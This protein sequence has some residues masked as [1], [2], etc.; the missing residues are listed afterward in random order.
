MLA[1]MI[2]L[3]NRS[4]FHL[5]S[6]TY[7]ISLFIQIYLQQFLLYILCTGTV[8]FCQ[9]MYLC[10]M[11]LYVWKKSDIL[12]FNVVSNCLLKMNIKCFDRLQHTSIHIWCTFQFVELHQRSN[13]VLMRK[14]GIKFYLYM[15]L[16]LYRTSLCIVGQT[17]PLCLLLKSILV[18]TGR[19]KSGCGGLKLLPNGA[20][21]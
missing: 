6:S 14:N 9:F 15:C 12:I 4:G 2:Y 13:Y 1:Q 17:F 5:K 7:L 16:P 8:F 19:C 11:E 3:L 20:F 18:R 21:G 10:K